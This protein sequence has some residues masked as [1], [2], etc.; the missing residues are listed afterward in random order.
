MEGKLAIGTNA[1]VGYR[2]S[3]SKNIATHVVVPDSGLRP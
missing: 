2:S 1:A 3:D